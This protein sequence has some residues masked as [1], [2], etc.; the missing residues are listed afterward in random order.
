VESVETEEK[1]VFK[2]ID[3]LAQILC[4]P[5]RKMASKNK[6]SNQKK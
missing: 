3:E 4:G 2:N 5:I 6:K 1:Q